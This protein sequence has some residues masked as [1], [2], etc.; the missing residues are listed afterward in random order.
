[1]YAENV[2][3]CDGLSLLSFIM[4]STVQGLGRL[5]EKITVK[6]KPEDVPLNL[7]AQDVTTHSMTLSWAPPIKLNPINY[8]VRPALLFKFHH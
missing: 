7:R 6:V 8:K 3:R 4:H 1:V 2:T 5:S